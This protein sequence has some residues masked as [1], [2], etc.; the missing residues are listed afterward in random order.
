[1]A[2]S[3]AETVCLFDKTLL[4]SPEGAA[5]HTDRRSLAWLSFFSVE[6]NAKTHCSL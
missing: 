4:G 1:M 5:G 3:S 6:S 2:A